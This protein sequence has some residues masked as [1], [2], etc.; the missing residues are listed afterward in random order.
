M[1]N[2]FIG[3]LFIF[4]F[5][6]I[7]SDP[8]VRID[9]TKLAPSSIVMR[10]LI[11][12]AESKLYH[13]T[14]GFSLH[15]GSQLTQIERHDM[16]PVARQLTQ[17]NLG[18]FFHAGGK[19]ELTRLSD[20]SIYV[21]A[22]IPGRGGWP[23]TLWNGKWTGWVM[24][25]AV[26]VLGYGGAAAVTAEVTKVVVKAA[27]KG[28]DEMGKLILEHIESDLKRQDDE[29]HVVYTAM[30]KRIKDG[31]GAALTAGLEARQAIACVPANG[32]K[33]FC[34]LGTYMGVRGGV[35]ALSDDERRTVAS[36]FIMAYPE[37]VDMGKNFSRL[38]TPSQVALYK[39][40]KQAMNGKQLTR[41]MAGQIVVNAE[42]PVSYVAKAVEGLA[43]A[44]DLGCQALGSHWWWI[45]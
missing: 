34:G 20:D 35:A 29:A 10:S 25:Q 43:T 38:T 36:G 42:V 14:T 5:S 26:R 30:M 31:I 33:K 6:L 37:L 41:A 4:P 1:K 40:S 19:L 3:T 9:V 16:D 18:R 8:D 27:D 11:D 45:P 2:L 39:L 23:I 12:Q 17:A 28:V 32:Y 24:K 13:G 15:K 7:S 44:A 21:R 22:H